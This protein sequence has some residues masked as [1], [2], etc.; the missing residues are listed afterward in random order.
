MIHV[1]VRLD[2]PIGLDHSGLNRECGSS[3][4]LSALAPT[5]VGLKEIIN[6]R[7]QRPIMSRGIAVHFVLLLAESLGALIF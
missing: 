3:P 6:I 7:E 4:A 5:C 1:C 2:R